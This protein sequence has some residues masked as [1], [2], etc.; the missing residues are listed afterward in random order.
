VLRFLGIGAQKAGTSWL[1]QQLRQHPELAFPLGK[2]P[3]FWNFPHDAAAVE[4]YLASFDA[5][6][7]V[8]GEF[9][10]A[11]GVLPPETIAEIHARVP[12]LRMIY[13]IRNPIE[14]AWSAAKMD[15]G[16][17]GQ[18]IATTPAAWF[19]DHFHSSGS[20]QRGDY[21][22]CLRN[23][24]SVYPAEQLLVLRYEQIQSEPEALLNRCFAHL[25]VSTRDPAEL[26]RAGSREIIFAGDPT[27]PSATLLAE[28]RALY[29]GSIRQFA[30]EFALD[31]SA[32]LEP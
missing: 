7:A 25:G 30:A 21:A 3:H 14:R 20:R 12:W 9:T 19:L 24:L 27:P 31:L 28:L 2:E 22:T 23:W 10:P 8:A 11:Y 13:L 18:Q 17:A 16:F 6:A 32:W 29:Q 5:V 1:Y 26:R 4:T 15:C